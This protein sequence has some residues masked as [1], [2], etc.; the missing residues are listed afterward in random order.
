MTRCC[1]AVLTAV[2]HLVIQVL[3]NCD[4]TLASRQQLH[5]YNLMI[6]TQQSSSVRQ[7]T[8]DDRWHNQDFVTTG[9]AFVLT[10]FCLIPICHNAHI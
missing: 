7:M 1:S 3:T 2:Q 4:K 9:G 8:R 10:P 6:Q 5:C